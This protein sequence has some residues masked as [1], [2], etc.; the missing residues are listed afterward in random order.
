LRL[1]LA[2]LDLERTSKA[3]RTALSGRL[4]RTD[5]RCVRTT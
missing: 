1:I 2:G 5:P 4:R 3:V